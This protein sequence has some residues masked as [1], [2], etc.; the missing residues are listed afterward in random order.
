MKE[1]KNDSL[2]LIGLNGC[3]ILEDQER[4]FLRLSNTFWDGSFEL[5]GAQKIGM[6][7]DDNPFVIKLQLSGQCEIYLDGFKRNC[8][9]IELRCCGP[10]ELMGCLD[11]FQII[12]SKTAGIV[13]RGEAQ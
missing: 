9:E 10:M 2:G 6:D 1:R 11:W 4:L 7:N 3:L 13:Q 8:F 5:I 12:A